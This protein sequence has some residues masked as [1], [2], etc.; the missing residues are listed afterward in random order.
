MH[1]FL[2]VSRNII[3]YGGHFHTDKYG[4][5]IRKLDTTN[6]PDNV[7][8][9][10]HRDAKNKQVDFFDPYPIWGKKRNL[11]MGGFNFFENAI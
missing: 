2:I 6:S 10:N 7:T 3:F 9:W 5:F 4:Y 8:L 11:R 1:Q